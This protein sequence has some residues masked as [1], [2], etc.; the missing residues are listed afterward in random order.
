MISRVNN[1]GVGSAYTNNIASNTQKKE[2]AST[3]ATDQN[4]SKVDKLKESINSGEY[5]VDLSA[6][7]KKMADELL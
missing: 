5:K 4:S 3:T 6:L 1:S 2:G 7:S